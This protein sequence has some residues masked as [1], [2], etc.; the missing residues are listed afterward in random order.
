MHLLVKIYKDALF[1]KTSRNCVTN[2]RRQPRTSE[3]PPL[4][5]RAPPRLPFP[6]TFQIMAQQRQLDDRIILAR[7]ANGQITV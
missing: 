2:L 6:R 3:Y 4:A 7:S 5:E 1:I